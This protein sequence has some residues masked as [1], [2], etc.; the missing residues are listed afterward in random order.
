MNDNKLIVILGPTASGKTAIAANIAYQFNGEVI[1]GD[2]RQVYRGMDLGTGKDYDDYIVNG[3]Q[4]PY[5]LIDI[6]DAGEK[7]N[8]FEFQTDFLEAYTK[9]KENNRLPILCGGT[10]MYIDAVTKGYKLYPVP[11]KQE[12]REELEKFTLEELSEIL[13]NKKQLHNT[14]DIDT[15]KRA[16]RAIEIADFYE[17]HPEIQTEYP[18]FNVL[19]CGVKYQRTKERK[20]ITD[21]LKQR[22]DSGLIQEAEMLLKIG[23]SHDDLAYY[24]LEYKFLFLYIK[25]ELDYD[26]M[27]T[28]LNTAIHQFAKRQRTWFRK[29]EKEG[30]K[31]NWIEGELPF[32]EKLQ[33]VSELV[34]YFY[35]N[36]NP[37]HY[38]K[39]TT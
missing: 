12:L 13:T 27:F 37:L 14:S 25:G 34:M 32:E 9:I 8:V 26:E 3:K 31:I 36:L 21:R 20:N 10:G 2:S 33:R 6:R 39:K 29:M 23:V 17:N 1:S 19:Y 24:G 5:H 16:I 7:Y 15:K 18:T 11:P 30:V 28:K 35:E 22:L 4:I 38:T